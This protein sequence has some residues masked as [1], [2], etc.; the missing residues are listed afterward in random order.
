[1]HDYPPLLSGALHLLFKHFSQRAEVLQAFKQESN[2]LSPIEDGTKKPQIDSNKSNNYNIVK[3][4]LEAETMRHIFM[5]NYL[6]C[7]EISERVV[8]HFVH[9]IETHGRHVEYLRFL[10]TIVKADGKYVKKCQ[11]MVMTEVKI[12]YVNFVNH[13]YV[14]TE[15]EMKE[16]YASNHIWKLFENFLVDMARPVSQQL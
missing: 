9:C 10:Q 14:D 5:N 7:N 3:E 4:L 2:I 16:I 1:M 11:D 8:Q 12:A 13:C 6:L 15:V